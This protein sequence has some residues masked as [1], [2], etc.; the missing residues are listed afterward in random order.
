MSRHLPDDVLARFV[1]CS[2]PERQAVEAALHIDSCPY[3]ASRA[4]A[5]D[6]LAPA[7]AAM[8]DPPLPAFFEERVLAAAALAEAP[9]ERSP[10]PVPWL[11]MGLIGLAALLM[12]AGGEPAALIGQLASLLRAAFV[13]MAVA[14]R[15]LPDPPASL[16]LAALAALA[17]SLT[18]FRLLGLSRESA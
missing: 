1:G 18:A 7:F 5:L 10:T 15:H 11:G 17:C 12:V 14:A 3:C 2:L 13:A 9:A 4:V 6:P 16:P 8:D